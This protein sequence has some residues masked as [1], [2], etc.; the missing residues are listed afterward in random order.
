MITG[1]SAAKPCARAWPAHAWACSSNSCQRNARSAPIT[2]HV[3]A[4]TS[5]SAK[6]FALRSNRMARLAIGG[7][8]RAKRIH[9]CQV[10]GDLGRRNPHT[11]LHLDAHYDFDGQHRIDQP[12]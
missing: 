2:A 9:G 12:R 6:Q 1:T 10:L 11:E 3:S 5:T 7:D 8:E 4:R